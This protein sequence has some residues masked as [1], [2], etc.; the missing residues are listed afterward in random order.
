MVVSV[1]YGELFYFYKTTVLLFL[2]FKLLKFPSPMGNF[3]ISI[4]IFLIA[5]LIHKVS[6]RPL[7]GTFLFLWNYFELDD[8]CFAFPSPM[9]NFFISIQ[10]QTHRRTLERGSF[11]PL[12]G[13]F[14]FLFHYKQNEYLKECF[15]PL[16]GTFLFL[17]WVLW[18]FDRQRLCVS[19]PYGELF[20]FYP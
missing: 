1:P 5:L 9:G 14:L 18:Y 20:Y 11:R 4:L 16:W 7:W 17:L 6:F 3:F 19:V 2:F 10:E 15:R 12:W 13:T 8:G